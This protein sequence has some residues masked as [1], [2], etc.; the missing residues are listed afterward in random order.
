ML[1]MFWRW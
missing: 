1:N